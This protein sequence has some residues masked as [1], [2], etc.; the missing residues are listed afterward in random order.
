MICNP[1]GI[2]DASSILTGVGPFSGAWKP[3]RAHSPKE[4]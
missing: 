3:T 2:I 4:K 1:M